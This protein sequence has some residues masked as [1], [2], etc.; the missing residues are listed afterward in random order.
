[1]DPPNY[2]T[3]LAFEAADEIE[4]LRE[5]LK[6]FANAA[7]NFDNKHVNNIEEWF[8]YGGVTRGN[9][10]IGSITV[11]DLRKARAALKDDE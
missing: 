5:A 10:T 11:G 7:F 3:S 2:E 1:M 6:P 9:N 4:R 8:A